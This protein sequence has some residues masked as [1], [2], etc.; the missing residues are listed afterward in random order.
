[1]RLRSAAIGFTLLLAVAGCSGRN[2]QATART[3][4]AA[5]DVYLPSAL[6]TTPKVIKSSKPAYTA[7]AMLR[8]IQGEVVVQVDVRPDGTVGTVALVKSLFPGLD[9]EAVKA[10]KEFQ[11]EPGE[12]DG[13]PVTVRTDVA[14]AFNLR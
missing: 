14:L 4:V 12:K 7:D 1:M 6:V 10:V 9:E 11:F 13:K 8:R 2:Q 3:P 5:Q